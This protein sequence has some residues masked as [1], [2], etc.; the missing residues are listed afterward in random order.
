MKKLLIA[1]AGIICVSVLCVTCS[2]MSPVECK[3]ACRN[4]AAVD[5]KQKI[6]SDVQITTEMGNCYRSCGN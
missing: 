6:K 2:T 4:K 5:A 3:K 1:L